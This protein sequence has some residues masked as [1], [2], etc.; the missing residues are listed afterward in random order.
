MTHARLEQDKKSHA[1]QP[2][3]WFICFSPADKPTIA[4]A[5]MVEHGTAGGQ[6][7]APV[8]GQILARYFGVP[9]PNAPEG[10]PEQPTPLPQPAPPRAAP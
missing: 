6:S 1:M 2:H 10:A 5:V 8:A 4:M 7:A 9:L 3:G